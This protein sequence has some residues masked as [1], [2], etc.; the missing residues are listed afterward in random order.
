MQFDTATVRSVIDHMNSD[1]R[2]ACVLIV[3]AFTAH[4]DAADALLKSLDSSG[5]E[6]EVS[7]NPEPTDGLIPKLQKAIIRVEFLKPLREE[8]QIRGALVGL[9][10]LARQR[11]SN[12]DQNPG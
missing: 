7:E 6:F 10:K 5:V 2:D 11:V 1:H 8:S 12:M 3:R 9:T 4:H